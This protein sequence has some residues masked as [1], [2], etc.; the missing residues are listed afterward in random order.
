MESHIIFTPLPNSLLILKKAVISVYP[1]FLL[2]PLLWH[3]YIYIQK[4]LINNDPILRQLLKKQL[5]RI[6][7]T[8]VVYKSK[9]A[10][11]LYHI[12]TI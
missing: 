5:K 7:A 6:A 3:I 4:S 2:I 1:C 8:K 10:F 11:R 12:I 9:F